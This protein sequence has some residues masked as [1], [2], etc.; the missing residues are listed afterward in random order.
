MLQVVLRAQSS[1][2]RLSSHPSQTYQWVSFTFWWYHLIF[3]YVMTRFQHLVAIL[4][5][6]HKY[7]LFSRRRLEEM[8]V[9]SSN[10]A[11]NIHLELAEIG[12]VSNVD[13]C[14]FGNPYSSD[15]AILGSFSVA[16]ICKLAVENQ[17]LVVPLGGT[18]SRQAMSWR[19]E[20]LEQNIWCYLNCRRLDSCWV[21]TEKMKVKLAEH[22]CKNQLFR[23]LV[24]KSCLSILLGLT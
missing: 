10:V 11:S 2:N 23:I 19:L 3:D 20:V 14:Y 16:R 24:T 5:F 22:S 13:W 1:L 9:H 17:W 6:G 12:K 18:W 4:H 8:K 7:Q 15:S 21:L